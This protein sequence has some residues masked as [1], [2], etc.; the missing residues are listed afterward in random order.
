MKKYQYLA[1]WDDQTLTRVGEPVVVLGDS[2]VSQVEVTLPSNFLLDP[3]KAECRM[4]FL[5]PGEKESAHDVL[6]TA[7]KDENGDSHVTWTIKHVHS[8]KG[9]RLAF[10]LTLIGDDAQWD[11]RTVIIP[12]YES[13]YQPESEEAEEPYTG[14]LDALEGSMAAIRGEFAEVQDDFEELK[15][16]A[17]LGTPIPESLVANMT[18][19]HAYIYTGTEPGYTAG[20]VYYYV[21]GALTDGGQYGGTTVDATLTQSGQAADAKV[22]GDKIAE[23]KEDLSAFKNQYID[24]TALVLNSENQLYEIPTSGN[25]PFKRYVA[26]D[27]VIVEKDEGEVGTDYIKCPPYVIVAFDENET[28]ARILMYFYTLENG[29]Y[30]PTWDVLSLET[31]THIKNYLS[32]VN[33][34]NRVLSIPDGLYMKISEAIHGG[35]HVYGW[36]GVHFGQDVVAYGRSYTDSDVSSS[37]VSGESGLLIPGNVG[38]VFTKNHV[39]KTVYAVDYSGT[40]TKIR[41][42]PAQSLILPGGYRY[43]TANINIGKMPVNSQTPTYEKVAQFGNINDSFCFVAKCELER[44]YGRARGVID[45]CRKVVSIRWRA[46]SDKLTIANSDNYFKAAT[47]YEGIPYMSRWTKPCYLG[48]HISAHTFVNA[49]SD[50]RSVFY[51]EQGRNKGPGYGLVC[52]SFATLVAGFPYPMTNNGFALDPMC[53][54]I[55]VN[56]PQLGM[57]MTKNKEHCLIVDSFGRN[58]ISGMYSLYEQTA[59]VTREIVNYDFITNQSNATR[60]YPYIN[61]YIYAVAH[62]EAIDGF[63]GAYDINDTTLVDGSARPN[64]GDKSVYTS[65]DVVRINIKDTSATVCYLQKCTYNASTGELTLVDAPIELAIT[66]GD[67]P[68]STVDNAIL[69]DNCF[70]AVWTDVDSAKE[71]FEYHVLTECAYS[72]TSD[73]ITFTAPE[74]WYALWWEGDTPSGI[75]EIIPYIK[76]GDYTQYRKVYNPGGQAGYMFFK[77]TFGAYV[78]PLVYAP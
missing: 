76:N 6:E 30:T 29:E 64:R 58:G 61:G 40:R 48:W 22:T 47:Y 75:T 46:I 18:E 35:V 36:S 3:T 62:D 43:F 10:S 19:G 57:I 7:V 51:T 12:V 2:N 20:H 71:Y 50:K 49:A 65:N 52:S 54:E 42:T 53:K 34:R 73:S 72:M 60:N 39:I 9:G 69:D 25:V 14:R 27:G 78:A 26:Q 17:T 32:N 16:T 68:I 8:Q 13:R 45:R 1:S 74:F 5:L 66:G 23:I 67:K 21:D 77:G 63:N 33:S 37:A 15:E 24:D 28:N 55:A 44:V 38:L 31:S 56:K 4:Y 70:Y 59:P 41:T 11:S